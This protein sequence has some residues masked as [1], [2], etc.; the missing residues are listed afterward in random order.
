MTTASLF[1]NTD[2][3]FGLR[4]NGRVLLDTTG[5]YT[6]PPPQQLISSA[7]SYRF[8]NSELHYN[9]YS[10]YLFKVHSCLVNG[11]ES[12]AQKKK[13]VFLVKNE[14]VHSFQ[15]NRSATLMCNC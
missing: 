8:I 1:G 3:A 7:Q 10:Y 13:K 14:R 5:D 9:R 15:G 6:P 2:L 12:S 4:I 11:C